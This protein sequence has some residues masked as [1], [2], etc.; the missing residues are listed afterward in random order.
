MFR[1]RG[2]A[3]RLHAACVALVLAA[4]LILAAS[5]AMASTPAEA[6][7]PVCHVDEGT[8]A[9]EPVR[10]SRTHEGREFHFCS[11]RCAKEFERNPARYRSAASTAPVDTASV[12]F[13]RLSTAPT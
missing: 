1:N 5:P 6:L 7:C 2:L 3:D 11:E 8:T 9:A 4:T 13:P 12:L 10:A